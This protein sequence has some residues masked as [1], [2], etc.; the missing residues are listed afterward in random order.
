MKKITALVLAVIMII[1]VFAGCDNQTGTDVKYLDTYKI[2]FTSNIQS[3]NPYTLDG[4]TYYTWV[5]NF[6]DGLIETDKYG[7]YQP[8][9][10][11]SW[12]SGDDMSVWTF[13]IRPGQFFIDHTGAKTEYEVTAQSFVEALRYVAD[14]VN[15]ANYLSLIR[16][17]ITGLADYYYALSDVDD[18]T[19]TTRTREDVEATFDETVGCKAVDKYTLEYTLTG[20]TPYFLSFLT[21]ETFVPLVPEFVEAKGEDFGTSLENLLYCGGYYMSSWE[22]DKMIVLTKNENYWD[23]DKITLKTLQFE[24]I[25]DSVSSVEMFQRGEIHN[26]SLS[27]EDVAAV[28]GGDFGKYV[29]LTEKSLSTYWFYFN[30]GAANPEFIA[31]VNNENFRKAIYYAIN[32]T[33]LSAIWE[34]TNPDAFVRNTLLPEGA[35]FDEDLVD[36]TDY[37]ALKPYK[38]NVQFDAD[39]AK[40]YIGKAVSELTESDGQTLK[41]VAA[42]K[43]DRLPISEWNIDGKLPIDIL[44]TSGSSESEMK[45]SLLVKEMLEE[46][47]G[48]EN[49]N[50]ILGYSNNSFT[51][52]VWNTGAW[53]LVDDVFSFR[54]ADPSANLDR[55]TTDYDL[56][57]CLYDIPEYD[58]MIADAAATY[59][60]K[61]RFTKYSQ[62]E[63]WMMEHAYYIPY[64]SGGGSYKMS[65]LVPYST[66]EGAFGMVSYRYKGALV[67]DTPVT[68]EQRNELKAAHEK[69]IAE[70]QK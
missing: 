15:D 16:N 37:P 6:I 34:E 58:A 28:R 1:G 47:L 70:L 22:R 41:G 9:L 30:F 12:S 8:A 67:Q 68:L 18:G 49:V 4:S 56:N 7:R 27:S 44:Y 51:D 61:E 39:K 69:E 45:K 20:P 66:P 42:G 46:Y 38:D 31:A 14:P 35:M 63:A 64:V 36:Y 19:D 48:K 29:Y 53:D 40:E 43:V 17:V 59:N 32:R 11:E 65:N 50:V 10:A 54:F 3:L 57:D 62:A 33:T 52:E 5:A 55:I 60:V 24:K 2:T 13:K 21:L 25:S 23:K 26:V